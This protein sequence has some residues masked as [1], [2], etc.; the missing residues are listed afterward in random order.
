M[1]TALRYRDFPVGAKLL[2]II[3]T[4]VI[5][6]LVLS[7]G[8]VLI[9]VD[10][11]LRASMR[12]DLGTLAEVLGSNSTAALAFGDRR[13]AEEILSGLAARRPVA[14]AR[15]YSA[16]GSLLAAYLRPG[17]PLPSEPARRGTDASWFENG[18]LK[19][20]KP[21]RLG[22]DVIGS[23]HMDADM[24]EVR[25]GIRQSATVILGIFLGATL[26]AAALAARLQRTL[27]EPIRR[28]AETARLV[29]AA[30]NYRVRAEKLGDDD[31]GR[32]TDSF[33]A[34]LVEIARRDDELSEHRDRLE[35]EV[36]KRTAE[37]LEAKERAEAANRA[38][39][40]FLANMSHEIRTP[41]NGVI[42]MT[43]L[44]LATSL[45]GE[46]RDYLGIVRS[47]GESLLNVINDI[48]DFSKIEAGKL[49][50]ETAEFSPGELLEE[51]VRMMAFTAH[52][53]GIELLYE[54]HPGM[55]VAVLGDAGRLRQVVV[56]LLGNAI[57]FT[58]SGEVL[59]RV[60]DVTLDSGSACL[61]FSVRD[62]GIGIPSQAKERIF[63]A[64]VQADDSHTRRF[65]GTGLG[66]AISAR[67]VSLMGGRIWVES[68]TGRGST[69]HFTAT[70]GATGER[71]PEA[72]VEPFAGVPILLADANSTSRRILSELLKRWGMKPEIADSGPMALAA[73][74][75][76]S[77]AGA[78]FAI[79]LLDAH[80]PETDGLDLAKLIRR[81]PALAGIPVPMLASLDLA[82]L[83]A[84]IRASGHFLAKPATPAAL[85]R[86]ISRALGLE[87][88]D[89]GPE[90]AVGP[91]AATGSH[92]LRILL[93]EDNPVNQKVAV[94]L[95]ER[96]G[97]A[98]K[99]A[100]SGSEAIDISAR[101]D[102][103]VILMDVQMPGVNGYDAARAIRRRERD[104]LRHTPIVALTANAMTGDREL[105]LEAGMD[106]YLSKPIRPEALRETL[107][108]VCSPETRLVAEPVG[109]ASDPPRAR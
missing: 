9:H 75:A 27:S 96:I 18:R 70:L 3:M 61:Q 94:L 78:P 107:Q 8:A 41:M 46:Q 91:A 76:R 73:M 65:G 7:G 99:L 105:C 66:L 84:E 71:A 79:A 50:L 42:G 48:L 23:I 89:A 40:Q 22:P 90:P 20:L 33:N 57:K 100:A 45:S 80:V 5:A 6:A 38:K 87:T 43:E 39:S 102:F 2:L 36:K 93:A 62:T 63:E 104:T 88:P 15:I 54:S 67:L 11:A 51:I 69:F 28:L 95:L 85:R 55:P 103:D 77:E 108:R 60:A 72:G 37:L 109:R 49:A 92:P 4:T 16:D 30:R 97:H 81:D 101:E 21:I 68:E 47:S 34:M 26:L 58:E 24:D 32:L 17:E 83:D 82:S 53:K 86:V 31:L 1:I 35:E 106:D 12:N 10:R 52:R 25:A 13:A 64:F 74:R 59:L 98:V 44:A 19:L 29:S 56:N 14:S